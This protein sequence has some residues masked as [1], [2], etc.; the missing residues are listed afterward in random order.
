MVFPCLE[1]ALALGCCTGLVMFAC[2]KDDNPFQKKYITSRD[3]VSSHM[4]WDG[5]LASFA[6]VSLTQSLSEFFM[7]LRWSGMTPFSQ[8]EVALFCS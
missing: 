3:Q 1:L 4:L 5:D 8:A 6:V 7:L 2:Y